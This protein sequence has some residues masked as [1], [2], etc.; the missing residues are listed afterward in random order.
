MSLYRQPGRTSMRTLALVAA[1]AAIVALAA[2]F[3]LGRATAP[4]P[5]LADKMADVRIGLKQA[6]EGI[7]L[8]TTEYPQAV[9][10]G[11]GVVAPTEYQAALDDVARAQDAI[12][13]HMADLRAIGR[14]VALVAAVRRLSDAVNAK[15]DPAQVQRLADAAARA[16]A[17]VGR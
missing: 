15:A 3:A 6:Q 13:A 10:K 4:D 12:A 11:G 2:G 9:G 7:E 5:T 16:L 1:A 14:D 17:A 8:V